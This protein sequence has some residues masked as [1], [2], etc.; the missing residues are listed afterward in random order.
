MDSFTN[1]KIRTIAIFFFMVTRNIVLGGAFVME[2]S[3]NKKN[4][5]KGKSTFALSFITRKYTTYKIFINKKQGF[6]DLSTDF[7]GRYFAVAV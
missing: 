7:K 5:L 1:V 6:N 2:L 4:L 3:F